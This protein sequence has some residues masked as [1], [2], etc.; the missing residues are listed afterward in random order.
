MS[1]STLTDLLIGRMVPPPEAGGR[2]LMVGTPAELAPFREAHALAWR[3]R[4]APIDVMERAIGQV[5][6]I[7]E[8]YHR[9]AKAA[10]DA[11]IALQGVTAQPRGA[12]GHGGDGSASSPDPSRISGTA[13][14]WD[15][16]FGLTEW[17]RGEVRESAKP[18]DE[19]AGELLRQGRA[20]LA[21]LARGARDALAEA[22]AYLAQLVRD[23]MNTGLILA[24][25]GALAG[26]AALGIVAFSPIP[27][28]WAS[29]APVA[30]TETTKLGTA[31]LSTQVEI[32]KAVPAVVGGVLPFVG[33]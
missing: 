7:A 31:A 6:F 30:I 5:P 12:S 22:W 15:L 11:Y 29:V 3:W 26:V 18:L 16:D 1:E 13:E 33:G 14:G 9:G 20:D 32:V 8:P 23:L 24:G 17:W 2:D 19:T 4:T 25:L 21:A 27:G 28:A 10:Q